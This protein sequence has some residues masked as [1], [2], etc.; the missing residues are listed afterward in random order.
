MHHLLGRLI[1]KLTSSFD[2]RS[3]SS[4]NWGMSQWV[5]IITRLRMDGYRSDVANMRF[6]CLCLN[7]HIRK[8]PELA[9]LAG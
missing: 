4:Q 2:L 3:S 6:G 1:T 8:A 5:R 7:W 9:R